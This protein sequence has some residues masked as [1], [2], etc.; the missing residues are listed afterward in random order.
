MNET[1]E[2][3]VFL[4]VSSGIFNRN[5]YNGVEENKAEAVKWFRKSAEQGDPSGQFSL[6]QLYQRGIGVEQDIEEAIKW[7]R[8]AAEQEEVDAQFLLAR[9]YSQEDNMEEAIKWL[10]KAAEQDEAEAQ[11]LL[12]LF[13]YA[14]EGVDKDMKEAAKWWQRAAELEHPEAQFHLGY[15]YLTGVSVNADASKAIKWLEKSAEQENATAQFDLGMCYLRGEG[16][17]KD[18]AKALKWLQS[19]EQEYKPAQ[20]VLGAHAETSEMTKKTDRSFMTFAVPYGALENVVFSPDGRF[21][22]ASGCAGDIYL[23][24]VNSRDPASK[25]LHDR[26]VSLEC[27]RRVLNGLYF[28]KDGKSFF[29]GGDDGKVYRWDTTSSK[30]LERYLDV[31]QPWNNINGHGIHTIALSANEEW[32]AASGFF[33]ETG[34]CFVVWNLK[35]KNLCGKKLFTDKDSRVYYATSIAFSPDNRSLLVT[36]GND[37]RLYELENDGTIGDYESL[38]FGFE[39]CSYNGTFSPSGRWIMVTSDDKTVKVWDIVGKKLYKT[40]DHPDEVRQ[41]VFSPDERL[42]LTGCHD[43]TARLW[44]LET[45]HEVCQFEGHTDSIEYGVAFSPKGDMIATASYDGTVKL[46]KV[47]CEE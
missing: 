14:G 11:Y 25:N 15:C 35:T 32:L 33:P 46:W 3:T 20:R 30:L 19:A 45:G 2:N 37:V 47:P 34:A 22:V 29:S 6:G 5:G 23:W 44:N 18:K 21:V 1:A 16:V 17:I 24:D 9:L 10:R 41:A 31:E 8:K 4:A 36:G 28:S 27:H 12:G 43:G 38:D 40:F 39:D 26:S 42:V 13:Y 7:I